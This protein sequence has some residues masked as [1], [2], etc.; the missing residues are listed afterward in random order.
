MFAS[1]VYFAL[2]GIMPV[3]FVAGEPIWFKDYGVA[4]Q[5][6]VTASKPLIVLIGSGER[7]WDRVSKDGSWSKEV[8]QLLMENY[9]CVYV[10]VDEEKGKEL[11]SAFEVGSTGLVISNRDGSI[12]VF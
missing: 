6:G 10:D 11:A 2:S 4:R 7:G 3:S 5:H 1:L 9:V 8:Q 12:Q